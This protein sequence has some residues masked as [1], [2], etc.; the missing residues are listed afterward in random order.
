MT[1][2]ADVLLATST[3]PVP[4]VGRPAA[5]GLVADLA[6]VHGLRMVRHP[7]YLLGVVWFVLGVGFAFPDTPYEEY[8]AVTGMLTFAIGPLAF[9]A[10]NLVAT[11]GRRSGADEWTPS[12]PMTPARRTAA[13]LLACLGPA[14]GAAVLDLGLLA[15]VDGGDL[16]W[17]VAWQ[18]VASV[19]LAVLG[20]ALLGVAVGRLLPWPGTPIGVLVGL[21]T[22]N[23]WVAERRPMLG[24]YVDFAE[25]T[26]SDAL[27]AIKPG[28]PT[29]HLVYL[30][31]L[32]ALA[33][34]GA[35]LRDVR[36][37]WLPFSAG[38]ALGVLVLV[39]G[40]AQLP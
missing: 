14:V 16:A 22:F 23:A 12:L 8:S 7:L 17:P 33:A 24:F 4:R 26:T 9:L 25:W 30:A 28:S 31:A 40:A 13:L 35:L 20:G 36:R 1:P 19:P 2:R 3:R 11:S 18:H 21:V 27:P 6:R 5:W 32:C 10:A 15:L 38:V 34:A 39:A 29:W 37:R